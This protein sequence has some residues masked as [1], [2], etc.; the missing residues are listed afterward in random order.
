MIRLRPK[1]DFGLFHSSKKP[2]KQFFIR[3][4][5]KYNLWSS[6]L[7]IVLFLTMKADMDITQELLI[8]EGFQI[9]VAREQFSQKLISVGPATVIKGYQIRRKG[10]RFSEKSNE[11]NPTFIRISRVHAVCTI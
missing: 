8:N 4:V 10:R 9:S 5:L 11:H 6:L 3:T 1:F 2:T 7:K